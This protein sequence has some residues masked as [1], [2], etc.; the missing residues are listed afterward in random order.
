MPST[1]ELLQESIV[2]CM[3]EIVRIACNACSN[4]IDFTVLWCAWVPDTLAECVDIWAVSKACSPHIFISLLPSVWLCMQCLSHVCMCVLVSES[5]C[6][7]WVRTYTTLCFVIGI[8][9]QFTLTELGTCTLLPTTR[10][11][12]FE[13]CITERVIMYSAMPALHTVCT[14]VH[15]YNF[16]P[17]RWWHMH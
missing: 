8:A 7:H 15:A 6:M 14:V 10:V 17:H 2:I 12:T 4:Y 3:F 1:S 11:S 13:W 5:I 16:L 9:I